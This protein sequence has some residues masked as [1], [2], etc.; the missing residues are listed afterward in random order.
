MQL[1]NHYSNKAAWQNLIQI[2]SD[3]TFVYKFTVKA[4]NSRTSF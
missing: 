3:E 4:Q 1:D 2:E